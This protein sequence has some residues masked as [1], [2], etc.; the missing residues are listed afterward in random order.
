VTARDLLTAPAGAITE[1]GLRKNI[2]VALRYL[3]AWLAGTGCVPIYDL[4]EDAATAEISRA[5]VWQWLRHGARLDSGRPV[6]AA[7][8]QQTLSEL[9]ESLPERV[10]AEGPGTTH[11]SLAGRILSELATGP[12][13]AEFLT[14]VAYEYLD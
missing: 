4:M 9:V 14:T 12:E 2:D 7:A 3:A 5:Q 10:G 1:A 6:T 11:F 8:V 13:F